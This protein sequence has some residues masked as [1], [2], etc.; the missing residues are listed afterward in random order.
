[1]FERVL[2]ANRGEIACRVIRTCRRLG[3]RTI[4]VYSEADRDAQHVRLADEAWPIGGP[5]PAE[6]Y[7]RGDAILDVARQTGAQAIHPGYG[8]LSENTGFARACGEAGIVFIGPKPESID[9]M[10]S[11]AAAKALMEKHAVPLVPG[12]H[13]ANQDAAALAEQAARTGFPLMI[14]AAAGGG[15]KGMR[16]VRGAAEF[17]DALASAQRE[18]ASSFGDSR[19]ILERYVE[20]PRHIE[21]QVFGDTQGHVIHLNERECSAQRRYQKVLEETPSPFLDAARRQAM[22]A[23][24]VAAAKAVDYVG[25]GTVEF[26][27]AQS[28]EFFF[29][30]MNTRLQ[31]EHPVTEL[32]LGLDLVEWQLRVAAGEA[33]PLTQDQVRAH[34]HAI[35]VRLYAEDPDQNFLPGSGKLQT[36]CLPAA[37]AH[38]RLDG[39]VIEGDT[40]TIFY[41]PMIAKL[42]VFDQDRPQALQ[43][44]REALAACEIVGPKSNIGFLERLAR[45]P[46]VVEGRID[47]GY[48][49]RHLDE[50]L[51]G[52]VAPTDGVLFAAA[53]AVLLR[54]ESRVASAAADPHSPWASADAWRIGHA[55]K[56]IVALSWREQRFEIEARGHAGD[57]QLH[58]G[59]TGCSVRGARLLDDHFSAR[60]D[61]ESRRVPLRSDAAHVLLHDAHGQ[62]YRF[63]RAAAFAWATSDA[64]G[65]NQ[66]IAP[67]PGR[68]VLVKASA[69]DAVEQGQELLVMEAMKMELA[70]KAPRAGTIES[71][72]AAQGEFVEADA[73]L[74]R[75]AGA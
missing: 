17:A 59:E 50:F 54:D 69:G 27:V 45:H 26:I 67:M 25:A 7:L 2:I 29:M 37:S 20:H 57:Y 39:G 3:I 73:V 30:E 6:S 60:F 35:E 40:V 18:A 51:V 41:D 22:G 61:G 24:A 10:G 55:G 5:L 53:T 15:G 49:D 34:G 16:I 9:A 12:Y 66:V 70:L 28:G 48:L 71:V 58:H 21:F 63:A 36:L 44:L 8:F 11:K 4:A 38:V 1:M 32:T 46:A 52:D 72:S 31:V 42:I 56:R 65:S 13:G 74:V 64:V 62:R 19:V 47:T 75:F 68:I 14:K 23:A 33:L 43:R